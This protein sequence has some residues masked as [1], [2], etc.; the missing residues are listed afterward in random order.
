MYIQTQAHQ[1]HSSLIIAV[2]VIVFNH[3]IIS[4][5]GIYIVLCSDLPNL[6]MIS[7]A[8]LP[9]SDISNDWIKSARNAL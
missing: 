4:L 7:N 6:S 8:N 2:R 5:D 1:V 3:I 9:I